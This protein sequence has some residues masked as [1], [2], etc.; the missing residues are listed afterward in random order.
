MKFL[1][2]FIK[3]K[4]LKLTGNNITREA[5]KGIIFRKNK[6]LLIHSRVNNDYKFPG[7]GIEKNETHIDTL[8]RELFEE[9]GAD[10]T[11]VTE[12]FG[13]VI[14]YS[15]A[16]ESDYDCFKMTSFYYF[17]NIEEHVGSTNLDQYEK[18]LGFHPVWVDLE[19]AINT[20]NRIFNSSI[21]SERWLERELFILKELK[22]DEIFKKQSTTD[23]I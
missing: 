8:K 10:L 6:I 2:E 5:V 21:K 9:C 4:D 12:S 15:K 23:I 20:N 22:A 1:K 16:V 18:E 14:E 13:K 7:G 3:D 11:E 19:F 17:C